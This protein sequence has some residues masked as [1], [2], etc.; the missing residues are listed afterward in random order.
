MTDTFSLPTL[1]EDM[2]AFGEAL[3]LVGD[4]PAFLLDDKAKIQ[5]LNGRARALLSEGDGRVVESA[6]GRLRFGDSGE[7]ARFGVALHRSLQVDGE[8][9][10]TLGPDLVAIFRR[11]SLSA[12]T[13]RLTAVGLRQLKQEVELSIEDVR[14]VSGLT[15]AQARCAIALMNGWTPESYARAKGTKLKNVKY[16]LYGATQRLGLVGRAELVRYMLRTFC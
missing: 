1:R 15:K 7:E 10:A 5:C 14:R 11:P 12:S 4:D 6:Q 13:V 9:R 2:P 3:S 8:F 16:A